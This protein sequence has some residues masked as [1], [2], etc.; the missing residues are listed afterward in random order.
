MVKVP[1][2]PDLITQAAL[3]PVLRLFL[4]CG[5]TPLSKDPAGEERSQAH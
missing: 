2:E 4:A 3:L 5:F 1:R